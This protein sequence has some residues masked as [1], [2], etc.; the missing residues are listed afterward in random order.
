[1]GNTL[2]TTLLLTT[3]TVLF[4]LMGSVVGGRGGML[5]AFGLALVM[6][7]GAYWFSDR[8]ALAMAAAKEVPY[9]EAPELHRLVER[10]ALQARIPKPRVYRIES[11]TP[12]AFATGRDPGHAAVAVTAGIDSLLARDELAG[13]LAHELAHIKNRDTL[14]ATVV[15]TLAGAITMIAQMAQWA[16]LF[17]GFGRGEEEEGAGGLAGLA[18]GLLM[19]VLAPIAAALIQLAISRAR[20]YGADAVGA[21]ILGDP[22]PLARALQRLE[23]AN[24]AAP[25]QANPAAAH[26]F[27]VQPLRGGGI[28]RLFSTHPPI[29]ERVSRLNQMAL[30]PTSY[31]GD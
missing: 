8:M 5:F 14:I 16:L 13:V 25:M 17:G 6:N 23:A 11:R 31:L 20:E 24:Q 22:L 15:A 4:V 18:G 10:L 28:A 30:Q 21:H 27:T 7:F 9:E 26:Q 3:L 19:I 2:K 12:N 1:M 29:A